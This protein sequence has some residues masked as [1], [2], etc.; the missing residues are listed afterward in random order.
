MPRW[1]DVLLAIHKSRERN[2]YCEKLN[3]II[4]G[5]RSHLRELVKL[6]ARLRLIEIHPT[7]K[8][9]LLALTEKGKKTVASIM[10]MRTQI[11]ML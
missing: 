6:L 2:R 8:I 10:Q 4:K 7:R 1:H 11:G 9:K 5:S 3:R